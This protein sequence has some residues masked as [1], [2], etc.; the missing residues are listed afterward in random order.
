MIKD[1]FRS[2][3][4]Y[5]VLFAIA[6]TV[7][8]SVLSASHIKEIIF[9]FV[10]A[11]LYLLPFCLMLRFL[12]IKNVIL[13]NISVVIVVLSSIGSYKYIFVNISIIMLIAIFID[14]MISKI[15]G[16][17]VDKIDTPKAG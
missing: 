1:F 7:S 16:K 10:V 2:F 4:A 14:F 11:I 12:C 15:R 6:F 8:L 3:A 13:R 9:V 5:L 17:N